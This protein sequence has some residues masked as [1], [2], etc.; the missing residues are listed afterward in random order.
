[1]TKRKASESLDEWL[2]GGRSELEIPSPV[3][4]L[5]ADPVLDTS[6][7]TAEASSVPVTSEVV[8]E[9]S[10]R[11]DTTEEQAVEWFWQL[12]EQAGFVLW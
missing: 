3:T 12:L 8:I 5:S 11:V 4:E 9:S 2:N 6:P 1:M 10:T 7:A